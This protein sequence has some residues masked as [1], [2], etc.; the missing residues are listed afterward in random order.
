MNS[1]SLKKKRQLGYSNYDWHNQWGQVRYGGCN[2]CDLTISIA[3]TACGPAGSVV[4]GITT[5]G[6]WQV[7]GSSCTSQASGNSCTN[8]SYSLLYSQS[9]EISGFPDTFTF[10]LGMLSG[11]TISTSSTVTLLPCTC[12]PQCQ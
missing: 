7:A 8:W 4:E 11:S 9:Y 10:Y 5:C 1:C 2:F 6:S 12:T 3:G